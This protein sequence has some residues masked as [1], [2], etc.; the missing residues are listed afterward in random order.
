M[1]GLGINRCKCLKFLEKPNLPNV[2]TSLFRVFSGVVA[3]FDV[4]I[5]FPMSKAMSGPIFAE[6]SRDMIHV[7]NTWKTNIK[8][9]LGN[10]ILL[11]IM[12][13]LLS[14]SRFLTLFP[15][16]GG[17]NNA[18]YLKWLQMLGWTKRWCRCIRSCVKF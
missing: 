10:T 11:S 18:P 7:E 1:F 8:I 13:S 5:Y 6:I 9:M 16:G 3:I 2:D 12:S 17:V 4:L 15:N 14:L